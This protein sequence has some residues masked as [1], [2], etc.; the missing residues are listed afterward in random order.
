MSTSPLDT[1]LISLALQILRPSRQ[2]ANG[3]PMDETIDS[4]QQSQS[5]QQSNAESQSGE[6]GFLHCS[7]RRSLTVPIAKIILNSMHRYIIRL[8]IVEASETYSI[9]TG[10]MSTFVFDE[11]A[12]IA[13]TAYQN[14]KVRSSDP[15]PRSH[16]I[17]NN[18]FRLDNQTENQQQSIRQRFP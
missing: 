8:H 12:F 3:C 13:V 6:N 18:T 17:D 10:P 7:R 2:S 5:D 16:V 4:L 11:T 1:M 14:D 9:R 15:C